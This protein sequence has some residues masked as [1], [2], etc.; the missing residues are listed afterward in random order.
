MSLQT[1]KEGQLYKKGKINTEWRQR[2]FI[3]NGKQL[4]YF[5]GS[6]SRALS[7]LHIACMGLCAPVVVC[8]YCVL[9][10]GHG[11]CVCV[12]LYVGQWPCM[13]AV[14]QSMVIC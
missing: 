3:L 12:L 10:C 8:M 4:A 1:L 5:K 11:R 14:D 2:L 13:Y 7:R 9:I 6:V